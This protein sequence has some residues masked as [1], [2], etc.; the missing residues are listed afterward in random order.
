VGVP[1]SDGGRAVREGSHVPTEGAVAT[2][3]RT[4]TREDVERFAALSGDEG[5]HHVEPDD[6]GRLLVHG[7]LVGV[8]P[9]VIGGRRN[10]L[11]RT[12]THEFHRPV[13]TGQRITC[14]VTTDE[15]T[16]RADRYEVASS[17]VCRNEDGETV[18]S[19]SYEGVILHED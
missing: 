8:L 13:Y 19:A 16:E 11:A 15:V 18:M 5:D 7:L 10:V 1:T 3:E 14:E 2:V 4:F 17:A 12:M 6:E 9:T